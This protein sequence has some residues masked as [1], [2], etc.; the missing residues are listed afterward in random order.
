MCVLRQP[1][2]AK[3]AASNTS[4]FS[5]CFTCDRWEV[6]PNQQSEEAGDVSQDV[7]VRAGSWTVRIHV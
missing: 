1:K 6:Y 5:F 7:T 2:N 3:A 4:C